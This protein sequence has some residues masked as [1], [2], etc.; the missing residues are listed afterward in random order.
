MA[1][2]RLGAGGSAR[3]SE[4]MLTL[5]W[6]VTGGPPAD[7]VLEVNRAAAPGTPAVAVS[8]TGSG[9]VLIAALPETVDV[10][11]R[12]ATGETFGNGVAVSTQLTLRVGDVEAARY[13]LPEADV[14]GTPRLTLLR[15]TPQPGFWQLDVPP[16]VGAQRAATAAAA[17]HAA[18]PPEPESDLDGLA[19]D[20]AY[21]AR[22]RARSAR[23][24]EDRR[25]ELHLAVDRSAS[26]L[27]LVRG[28]SGQGLMDLVVGVN[29]VVGSSSTVA[30]WSL[31]SIPVPMRPGL[32]RAN[33][34]GRWSA[35]L[36]ERASTGGT[37]VAPLVA[38]IAARGPRRTVLVVT[39]GPPAD[40]PELTAALEAARADGTSTR[41]HVLALART[42]GDRQ[43]QRE[44]WRDELAGLAP[45]VRAGLLTCSGISPSEHEGWLLELLAD[46]TELAH[47]VD[48]LPFWETS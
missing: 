37:L 12:P 4:G 10:Q 40:L 31:G 24:P 29:D 15:L 19:R 22:R 9:K 34:G 20:A 13:L 35:D 5:D 28:G 48:A 3:C 44:P 23:L 41:W 6:R 11:V 18:A 8:P 47:V 7:V 36:V 21:A 25:S 27:P 39:D 46:E 38:E 26:M 30:L 45:L 17:P 14:S 43:V 16:D 1:T 2:L 42:S 33:A 32:T